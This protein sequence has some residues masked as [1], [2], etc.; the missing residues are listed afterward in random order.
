MVG[1]VIAENLPTVVDVHSC[2]HR[3]VSAE[4][5]KVYHTALRCPE[6]GMPSGVWV[7]PVVLV[8]PVGCDVQAMAHNLP[9]LIDGHRTALGPA[10]CPEVYHTILG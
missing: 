9:T 5:P 8:A 2:A 6:E 3:I 1:P 4:C 7:V 10:D